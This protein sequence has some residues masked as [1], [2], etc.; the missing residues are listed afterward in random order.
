MGSVDTLTVW[1]PAVFCKLGYPT[2]DYGD[3]KGDLVSRL[4]CSLNV[5]CTQNAV[6]MGAGTPTIWMFR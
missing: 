3:L 2:Y 6:P 5:I 1:R 4:V